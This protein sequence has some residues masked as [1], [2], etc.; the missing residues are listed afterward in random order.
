M[1]DQIEY[2]DEYIPLFDDEDGNEIEF[3]MVARVTLGEIS[4]AILEDPED[5]EALM[6]FCVTCDEEGNESFEAVEDEE[7]SEKVFYLFEAC[8]DDYEVGQ[9]T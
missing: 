2:T 4:Y 6:V 9:A 5:E 8:Y 1:Q 3:H 7:E